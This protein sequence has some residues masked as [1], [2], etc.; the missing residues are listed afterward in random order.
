MCLSSSVS[1]NIKNTDATAGF[2]N[3][4]NLKVIKLH[5]K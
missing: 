1:E 5:V 2:K 3:K 4:F